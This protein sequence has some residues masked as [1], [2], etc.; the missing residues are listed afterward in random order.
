MRHRQKQKEMKSAAKEQVVE[1][2]EKADDV[3][4]AV[5]VSSYPLGHE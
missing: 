2:R 3:G 5:S 1:V 4:L